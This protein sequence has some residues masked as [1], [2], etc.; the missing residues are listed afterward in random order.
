MATLTLRLPDKLLNDVDDQALRLGLGRAEYVRRALLQ[1]ST[2]VEKARLRKR[3][4]EVSLR[5]RS[6]SM[7][8]NAQFAAI[9]TEPS[10]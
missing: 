4:Q 10:A 6:E 5:V 3:L 1:M 8:V 7:A 2:S 9:E